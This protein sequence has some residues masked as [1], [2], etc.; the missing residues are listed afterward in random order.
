MGTSGGLTDTGDWSD[1]QTGRLFKGRTIFDQCHDA[2]LTW[3]YYYPTTPWELCLS[4]VL[5]NPQNLF[6]FDQ[7][8]QD[9]KEGTLPS[10]SWINP[11]S[12]ADA[13]TGVG[14]NDAHPSHDMA[15]AEAFLKD[16]Y[17]AVRAS[18]QYNST[19]LI[20]MYDEHGGFWDGVSPPMEGVPPPDSHAGIPVPFKFDRLGVR[21]PLIVLS[22][23]IP[24]GTVVSEPP[25]AQK[26][27]PTSQYDHTSVMAT[28]RKVLGF[29]EG[30]LTKRDAWSG[31][32]E[33][34]FSLDEPRTDAPMRAP[35]PPPPSLPNEAQMPLTDLQ[36]E[37][38][39]MHAAVSRANYRQVPRLQGQLH[40]SL[41]RHFQHAVSKV[42]AADSLYKLQI[43]AEPGQAFL[44]PKS[45]KD[46]T[47]NMRNNRIASGKLAFQGTPFCWTQGDDGSVEVQLC[48]N[49]ST[50]QHFTLE[51]GGSIRNAAGQCV[52]AVRHNDQS[53]DFFG[54]YGLTVSECNEGLM[55]SFTYYW[56]GAVGAEGETNNLML[57]DGQGAFVITE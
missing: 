51:S 48:R 31:T 9:A 34:I 27:F 43:E 22:P 21:V 24:R 44:R 47:W 13:L 56:N 36:R 28:F 45:I 2:N 7:F 39:E 10:F 11:R 38:F 30:P 55:Q 8:L 54:T 57:G 6:H 14:S 19:A 15:L 17:E 25:E 16:I 41:L 4:S 12:G 1:F 33:H 20:V 50:A 37:I 29:T 53:D 18:P 42:R 32:F 46:D 26:P 3:R 52:T 5:H 35:P 49:A 23:W 40:A